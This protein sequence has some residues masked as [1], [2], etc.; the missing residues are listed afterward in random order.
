MT[1][2]MIS[3]WSPGSDHSVWVLQHRSRRGHCAVLWTEPRTQTW[4]GMSGSNT[5]D[6]LFNSVSDEVSLFLLTPLWFPWTMSESWDSP[7]PSLMTWISCS[8]LLG[9][10]W[11]WLFGLSLICWILLSSGEDRLHWRVQRDTCIQ[12]PTT[13]GFSQPTIYTLNWYHL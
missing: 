10:G 7:L 5:D 6:I 1:G 3:H 12:W 4:D 13:P 11:I 2:M 8:F 9:G